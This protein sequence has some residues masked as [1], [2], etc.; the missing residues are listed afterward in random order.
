MNMAGRPGPVGRPERPAT[1]AEVTLLRPT[2][3]AV[4]CPVCGAGPQQACRFDVGY[5]H[6]RY[7]LRRVAAVRRRIRR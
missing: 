4:P 5:L 3:L 1:H 6:R 7:H 2:E